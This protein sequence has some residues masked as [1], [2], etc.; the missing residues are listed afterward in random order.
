LIDATISE[1]RVEVENGEELFDSV[2][3]AAGGGGTALDLARR[4]TCEGICAALW[5]SE[6]YES[7]CGQ[8]GDEV[9]ME[10]VIDRLLLLSATRR[11]ISRE[12]EFIASHFY[13]FL[14]R[15]DALKA[16]PVSLLYENISHGSLRVESEDGLYNFINKGT[17]TDREMFSLLEFV[18]FEYC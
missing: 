17:E 9:T 4:Q 1:L 11:G 14:H 6:L 10:N 16:L 12:L 8:L 3:E 2:L 13:G 18:R 7:V 15:P 5:N